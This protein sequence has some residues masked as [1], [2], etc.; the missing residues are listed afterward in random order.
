MGYA[1]MGRR[2]RLRGVTRRRRFPDQRY[3]LLRPG[4]ARRGA[5]RLGN[6]LV[7]WTVRVRDPR[8]RVRAVFS[9]TFYDMGGF[10]V[11]DEFQVNEISTGSSSSWDC[12]AHLRRRLV[13]RGFS[14]AGRAM[15]TTSRDARGGVRAARQIVLD[16]PARPR[17]SPDGCCLGNGVLDPG[18]TIVPRT[19]WGQR[20]RGAMSR[21]RGTAPLFHRAPRAPSN[22]IN[23]VSPHPTERSPR[24][25]LARLHERS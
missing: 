21:F 19:A 6:F 25:R 22:T 14:R 4:T 17:S 12:S 13:R 3:E 7:T 15:P 18:E 11:S 1:V 2:L 8:R 5:T 16:P 23:D 20:H 10:P 24:V 9:R